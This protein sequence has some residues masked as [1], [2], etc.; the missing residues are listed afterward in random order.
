MADA[1]LTAIAVLQLLILGRMA[2]AIYRAIRTAHHARKAA[3]P[4]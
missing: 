2:T 1:D 4:R 3:R